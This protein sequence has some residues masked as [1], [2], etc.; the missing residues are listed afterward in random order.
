MT[1]EE[2]ASAP[3]GGITA[4]DVL[5]KVNIQSGQKALI[6]GASGSAGTYAVQ[7]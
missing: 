4:L 7:L 1:H 2:A 6:C 3:A 5:R